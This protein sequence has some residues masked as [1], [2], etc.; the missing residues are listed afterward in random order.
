M[1]IILSTLALL[2]LTPTLSASDIVKASAKSSI[3]VSDTVYTGSESA[4]A[5]GFAHSTTVELALI[6]GTSANFNADTIISA[7]F[8]LGPR[9]YFKIS[10]DPHYHDGATSI[11]ISDSITHNRIQWKR[12]ITMSWTDDKVKLV[13]KISAKPKLDD[14]TP[15]DWEHTVKSQFKQAYSSALPMSLIAEND[16]TDFIDTSATLHTSYKVSGAVKPSSKGSVKVSSKQ[17]ES[18]KFIA[19]R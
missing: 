1:K 14:F 6:P 16:G 8:P 5:L 19:A 12:S 7:T 2:C 17:S 10:E 4:S 13:A 3:S 18:G 11:K 9:P 15:T